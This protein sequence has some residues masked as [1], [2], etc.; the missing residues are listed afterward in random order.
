MVTCASASSPSGEPEKIVDLLR[1]IRLN[2]GVRVGQADIFDRHAHEPPRD[3]ER[4]LAA[5]KHARKPIE[6]GVGV[7]AA[8][9][10]VQGADQ[11]VMAV[12]RFVVDRRAPLHERHQRLAV[13]RRL[14]A[15][16]SGKPHILGQE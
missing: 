5:G 1:R 3:V 13:E 11:I 10:F 16:R 14:G 9:R 12:L 6:R 2:E 15:G 4:V 7:R 8:H